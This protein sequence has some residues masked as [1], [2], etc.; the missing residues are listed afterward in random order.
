VQLLVVRHAIAVEPPTQGAIDDTQRPLTE[1]GRKKMTRGAGGLRRAI[2]RLDLLAA[3]PLLR[4]Q[5]TAAIVAEVFGGLEVVTVDE[6]A[7]GTPPASVGRWLNRQRRRGR[8]AVVGHEP[9]LSGLVSWLLAGSQRAV[10]E[11]RKGG[12]CLLEIPGDVAASQATL[13]WSLRP[14]HLRALAP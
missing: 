9:H 6:L 12:A 7:P 13:L 8:V 1:A 2:R 10:L 4:A 11:L 5:Q 14:R 3:S